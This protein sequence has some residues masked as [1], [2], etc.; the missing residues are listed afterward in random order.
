MKTDD[1]IAALAADAAPRGPS[2][3]AGLLWALAAALVIAALVMNEM[4][5]L[6]ADVLTSLLTSPRFVFK[7]VVTFAVFASALLLSLRLARPGARSSWRVLA[8]PVALLVAAVTAELVAVPE[9]LW[10]TRLVGSNWATCLTFAPLI[11]L[12]PLAVLLLALKRGAPESPLKAGL[13]AGLA[14][15]GIGTFFYAAHCPDDSPLFVAVWYTIVVVLM[16]ALGAAL[17]SRL[18]RW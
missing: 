7:F 6:R 10:L 14:A 17:G 15:G 12:G 16:G 4:L 11:S 8:V 5:G 1:L 9:G 3:R 18:L 13:V 2:L